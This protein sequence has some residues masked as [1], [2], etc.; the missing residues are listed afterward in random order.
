M[1]EAVVSDEDFSKYPKS[2][3]EARSEASERASD[4]TP[5]EALI[6]MLRDIDSGKVKTDA[7]VICFRRP[8]GQ[9]PGFVIASPDPLVT[10]GLL[11]RTKFRIHE[12]AGS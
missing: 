10:L 5:R 8:D 2:V 12:V 11:E 3:G 6:S 4:W 9:K 7:L 1:G